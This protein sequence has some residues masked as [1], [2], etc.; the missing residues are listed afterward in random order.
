VVFPFQSRPN[1]LDF[2]QTRRQKGFSMRLV[3]SL[4]LLLTF[5]STA[6]A[7]EFKFADKEKAREILMAQDVYYARMSPAEIAIRRGSEPADKTGADLKAYYGENVLDWAEADQAQVQSVI[8]ANQAAIE[9]VEHLLPETI[10][11]IRGTDKIEGGLSH[12]QANA[13]IY[14]D[15]NGPLPDH[16]FLHEVFHV[17]TRNNHEKRGDIYGIMGFHLCSL[18]EP[19]DMAAEHLTNPDVPFD[20]WYVPVDINGTPGA[21]VPFLYAAYPAFNPEVE[22][23]F[24][25]HFGFG[26]VEVSVADGVCTVALDADGKTVMHTLGEVPGYLEA[27]GGNT[28]YIIHPEE[29]SADNFVFLLLGKEDLKTPAIPEALGAWIDGQK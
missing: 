28:G 19:Q 16:V 2:L 24:G 17:L 25:G 21:V 10:W 22:H 5:S 12:T 18:N 7:V 3:A 27:L 23:G 11:L 1:S 14:Q 4:I 13:I 9:R 20:G 15:S 26:L 29:A 8:D 6:G